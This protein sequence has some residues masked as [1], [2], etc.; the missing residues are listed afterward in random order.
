M[1]STSHWPHADGSSA[2][3]VCPRSR[4]INQLLLEQLLDQT[5]FGPCLLAAELFRRRHSGAQ[6]RGL[7]APTVIERQLC[8]VLCGCSAR[9]QPI[10]S[11]VADK[12]FHCDAGGAGWSWLQAALVL[13]RTA[14]RLNHAISPK[15]N[16]CTGTATNRGTPTKLVNRQTTCIIRLSR[17]VDRQRLILIGA[18]AAS[19]A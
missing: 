9:T 13:L 16:C 17:S 6:K 8:C 5:A 14:K 15:R 3:R 4:Y 7:N 2:Q 12:P 1:Q 10:K 18:T 19:L 11:R